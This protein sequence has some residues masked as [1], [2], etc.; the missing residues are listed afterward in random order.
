[1]KLKEMDEIP[2]FLMF[3]FV[4]DFIFV[5]TYFGVQIPLEDMI[6]D[7]FHKYYTVVAVVSS[8]QCYTWDGYNLR[9]FRKCGFPMS[10]S[11]VFFSV[12]PS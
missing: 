2:S 5:E 4:L 1:M 8:F 6:Y 9:W 11:P 3:F 12:G 7:R 10:S